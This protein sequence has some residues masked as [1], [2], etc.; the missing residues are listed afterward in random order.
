[1]STE[2]MSALDVLERFKKKRTHVA[3]SST[4]MAGSRP[5]HDQRPL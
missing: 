3:L 4:S 1:M 5:R 2:T